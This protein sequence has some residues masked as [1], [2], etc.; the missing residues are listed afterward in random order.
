VRVRS[1]RTDAAY[2]GDCVVALWPIG[3]V[4]RQ[5]TFMRRP[6]HAEIR[7]AR[8]VTK[9][10]IVHQ[11]PDQVDAKALDAPQARTA[12]HPASRG[13]LQDCA[14]SELT[15][16]ERMIDGIIRLERRCLKGLDDRG[17]SRRD[18]D[19]RRGRFRGSGWQLIPGE[20]FLRE[21]LIVPFP[22]AGGPRASD[23]TTFLQNAS[24][25]RLYHPR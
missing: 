21:S 10:R 17:R 20:Y 24:C 18:D 19:A 25:L 4:E 1:E 23:H 6:A 5:A 8:I 13:G 2:L 15:A 12:S 3:R 7:I 11:V 16:G 22:W 14:N 9:L